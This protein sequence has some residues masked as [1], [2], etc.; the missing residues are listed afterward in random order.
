VV[1]SFRPQTSTVAGI[2]KMLKKMESI[3]GLSVGALVST[4]HLMAE[5]EA[6]DCVN[7]LENVLDAGR[8]LDLPVLFAGVD[9]RLYG[10]A[11]SI[12][13]SRGISV[14]LWPVARYMMLPWE[15]GA[16]WSRGETGD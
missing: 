15:D 9:P 12:M 13:E 2:E 14:P 4:S 10:E 3:C 6:E 16:M 1:N 5:T 7:G 11:E 8:K